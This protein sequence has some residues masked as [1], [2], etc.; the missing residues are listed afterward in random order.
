MADSIFTEDKMN[1]EWCFVNRS[2]YLLKPEGPNRRIRLCGTCFYALR[3]QDNVLLRMIPWRSAAVYYYTN[4]V[5]LLAISVATDPDE[6][7]ILGVLKVK[8]TTE[9]E[10]IE[11]VQID[12]AGFLN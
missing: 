12:E 7:L 1:C 9:F 8:Y 10:S 6:E 2:Q 11:P 4:G 5:P 3:G